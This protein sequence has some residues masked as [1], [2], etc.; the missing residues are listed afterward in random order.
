MYCPGGDYGEL[1][2]THE[3]YIVAKW[4]SERG[5]AAIKQIGVALI[6]VI[7]LRYCKYHW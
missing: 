2:M 1:W 6:L 3:G 4:L 7:S 5:I